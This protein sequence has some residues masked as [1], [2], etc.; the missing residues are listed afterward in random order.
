MP[1]VIVEVM[2]LTPCTPATE[3]STRF[4]TWVCSS[5]GAAPD[6]VIVTETIGQVDV[7][8]PGDRQA[9]EADEAEQQ[10]D[11]EQH[12]RRQRV[13][14]R[15]G[16]DVQ[17]HRVVLLRAEARRRA[18]SRPRRAAPARDRTASPVAQEASGPCDHGLARGEPAADLDEAGG[19]QAGARPCAPRPGRPSPRARP[20]CR[21]PQNRRPESG[22]ATPVRRA[23]STVPR[24][25]APMRKRRVVVERDADL[26]EPGGPV[27]LRDR[28]GGPGRRSGARR[29][30]SSR[31]GSPI[32]IRGSPVS[33]TSPSSSISP[34]AIRRNRGSPTARRGCADPRG[35]AVDDAGFRRAD[36]GA[37]HAEGRSSVPAARA[38]ARS[39]SE[40]W[41]P[42]RA[43]ASLP[44]ALCAAETRC[45]RIAA[46][47]FPVL[48]SAWA[49]SRDSRASV[50][51]ASD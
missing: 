25:K 50:C 36:R 51:A 38:V 13:A 3:S 9:A 37:G 4:V 44:S 27:D 43:A 47:A 26:A 2:C 16:G 6:W 34:C 12:D 29:S 39:A 28:R 35:A 42:P 23:T 7:G 30:R 49:R 17:A 1:S 32:L 48:I 14:D 19:R 31:A 40:A 46:V 10:Q 5:D 24:A 21:P 33:V 15:P 22:T 45:S 20:R 11:E 41:R 18:A 8:E